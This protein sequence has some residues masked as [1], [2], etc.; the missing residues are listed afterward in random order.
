MINQLCVA[1]HCGLP[2]K[3]LDGCDGHVEECESDRCDGCCRGCLPARAAD[4]LYLCPRCRWLLAEDAERAAEL[5][6]ALELSLTGGGRQGEKTSGG[7][8]AGTELNTAAVE[9]RS[10]IRATLVSLVRLIS[11]ER[12]VSLP[13]GWVGWVERLPFGFIGP[14]NR[15]RHRFYDTSLPALARMVEKHT[16]WL[17]AHQAADEHARDLR[18]L[19]TDSRTWRLAY[20]SASDRLYIGECPLAKPTE[21]GSREICGSR[22]YQL[23][24]EVLVTC[25]GCD[26]A[27]TVE[28]WQL[29]ITGEA[30][31]IVDAYAGA[32]HLSVKWRR[33]VDP[34]LVRKWGLRTKTTGVAAVTEVEPI[35]G[36]HLEDCTKKECGGCYR[37]PIR[38]DKNRAQYQLDQLVACAVKMWG[39]GRR[40]AA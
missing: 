22:L 40:A 30:G 13:W 5:Y 36:R 1:P 10:A 28:W 26:K 9:A 33:P 38:D 18:D 34:A 8:G 20:P 24:D 27:E 21:D 23:P 19:A 32:A 25:R 7:K 39:P 16:D 15:I 17:A 14:P 37:R 11:E 12:G 35:P 4:G 3:H 31:G 2:G 29:K 6:E